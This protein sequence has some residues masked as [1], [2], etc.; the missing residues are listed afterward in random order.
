MTDTINGRPVTDTP[1][2]DDPLYEI[3]VPS[4]VIE[5]Q[6]QLFHLTTNE[7]HHNQMVERLLD[8]NGGGG[9]TARQRPAVSLDPSAQLLQVLKGMRSGCGPQDGQVNT[10]DVERAINLATKVDR[11]LNPTA[12]PVLRASQLEELL[13][14]SC[15]KDSAGDVWIKRHDGLW[16][17]GEDRL[18]AETLVHVWAPLHILPGRWEA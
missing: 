5:G 16:Q 18:D 2:S 10:E 9:F 15:V 14:G 4:P 13:P 12:T 17:F 3:T 7:D 6:Q 11:L 1:A 8:N